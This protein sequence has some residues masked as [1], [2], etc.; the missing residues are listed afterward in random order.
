MAHSVRLNM[1]VHTPYADWMSANTYWVS[2][3]FSSG[4]ARTRASRWRRL[5]WHFA[6]AAVV[7]EFTVSASLLTDAG[8]SYV[9]EGG[10]ILEKIHPGSYLALLAGLCRVAD[11]LYWPHS[12]PPLWRQ[13]NRALGVFIG[14]IL[15]CC[16]YALAC[17][18]SGGVIA[19]VDTFL[20]AGM[21]ALALSDMPRHGLRRLRRL[22]QSLLVLNAM[23]ALGEMATQCH[24]V[25]VSLSGGDTAA[26]FR[27]T[28]FYD[29]PLTGAAATMMG[30]FLRPD[31]AR[32][33]VRSLG[34]ST[35]MMA[36]LLAF[37]ERTPLFLAVIALSCCYAAGLAEKMFRR[38]LRWWDA[39]P[40][41]IASLIGVLVASVVFAGGI[42]SRLSAH[43][44]W[45]ASAQ[46]RMTEFGIIPLLTPA[47][48]LFGCRRDDLLA[49]IEPLRLSAGVGALE[50][51]WLVMLATLGLF[52][53][54]LFLMALAGLLTWL[55]RRTDCRGRMMVVTLIMAASASNSLGR[56]STLLV[57][58]VASVLATCNSGRVAK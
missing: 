15:F 34:F 56:K 24:L 9:S 43:L 6:L 8:S 4:N 49:L 32:A 36:A 22:T 40:I 20:P 52:C 54:P 45:D 27:P 12:A 2:N 55:W 38:A 33:P 48:L 3:V 37:G 11:S 18:G 35:L 58:L 1:A 42:S 26:E 57:M 19:L 14:G 23:V 39:L 50:N 44:Y 30:V 47:E 21:L 31:A 25:P 17:S 41:L 5:S 16:A 13:R 46:V 10:D 51:F 29:H 28:G 7:V 53:F